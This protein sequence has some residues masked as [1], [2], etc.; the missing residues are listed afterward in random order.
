LARIRRRAYQQG[1]LKKEGSSMGVTLTVATARCAVDLLQL[2][3]ELPSTPP[4]VATGAQQH[5]AAIEQQ[6]PPPHH[7]QPWDLEHPRSDTVVLDPAT[8]DAVAELLELFAAMPSTPPE[9]ASDARS[10]AAAISRPSSA[11]TGNNP[12]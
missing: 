4:M 11:K 6:L 7:S 8:A 5:I 1:E 10:Q 9:L 2:L 3:V 12:T